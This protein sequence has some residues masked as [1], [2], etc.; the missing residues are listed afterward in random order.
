VKRHLT[1]DPRYD[2]VGSS[3][4]REEL[5]GT[6]LKAL[7]SSTVGDLTSPHAET[8]AAPEE[9]EVSAD[10]PDDP[11]DRKA[12]AQRGLKEREERVKVERLR[13]ERDIGQSKVNLV[14]VEAEREFTSFLVDAV[15]DPTVRLHPHLRTH[16]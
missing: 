5:F 10:K 3:S 13:I 14:G 11:S 15:T 1:H 8:Q 6:F 16:M 7:A 4:L 12:R 2:A 9:G